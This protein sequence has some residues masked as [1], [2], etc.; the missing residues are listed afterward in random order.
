MI[1]VFQINRLLHPA[2]HNSKEQTKK[3]GKM[4][5]EKA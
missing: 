2:I 4:F 5:A 3:V 1:T